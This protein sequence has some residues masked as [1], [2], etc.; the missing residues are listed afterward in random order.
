MV[1]WGIGTGRRRGRVGFVDPV[2]GGGVRLGAAGCVGC[3]I[4]G[5]VWFPPHPNP[6]P[7]GERGPVPREKGRRQPVDPGCGSRK[8]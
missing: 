4:R 7:Q 5:R 2:R 8:R 6:L 3:V 1:C